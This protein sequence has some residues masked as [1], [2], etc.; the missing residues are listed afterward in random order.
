MSSNSTALADRLDPEDWSM[1]IRRVISLMSAPVER[2]GGT[3]VRVMGDGLLALFGAPAAH[4]DDAI[5]AVHAGLEMIADVGCR[6]GPAP[7]HWGGV[8]DPGRHQHRAGHRR[9]VGRGLG[10]IGCAGKHDQ[11]GCPDAVGCAPGHGARHRRDVALRR[12]GVRGDR[13]W[14][15]RGQGQGRAGRRLGGPGPSRRA[16]FRTR[17]G[18]VGEPARRPRRAAGTPYRAARGGPRRTRPGSGH[19]R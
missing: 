9:R 17:A 10:P 7:G 18:R 3:V 4:E 2:Y 1:A 5:R 13:P 11:R 6:P 14:R 16:G 19:P 15:P 12:V 8:P